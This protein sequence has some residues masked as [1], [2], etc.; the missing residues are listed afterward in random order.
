MLAAVAGVVMIPGPALAHVTVNPDTVEA[1][2][3][4]KLAFRVP[5]ERDDASTTRVEVVFPQD[6]PL[7]HAS[8]KPV[9][10]WTSTVT[11]KK[12]AEPIMSGDSEITEV[13]SSI[14][15]KGGTIGAGEFQEFEVSAGRLPEGEAALAF[16]ALQTYSSGEVV[17]WIELPGADGAEPENPAPMLT[18]APPE[19]A[20][21]GAGAAESPT[22][23]AED[24]AAED[25]PAQDAAGGEPAGQAEAVAAQDP[26]AR[27]LA[28]AGLA[29]GLLA[30]GVAI[31]RRR[32]TGAAPQTSTTEA[33]AAT[34]EPAKARR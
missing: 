11:M 29:A 24:A 13:V 3:Y 25:A 5:N 9:P 27:W 8:V 19:A 34:E 23:A 33:A 28:G 20:N 17:R 10:G 31:L 12:L 7:G 22:D 21:A 6:N 14:V 15:W 32:P 4:A 1:G 2:G 16:K 18:V 26:G 30:L